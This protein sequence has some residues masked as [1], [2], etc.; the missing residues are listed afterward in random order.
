LPGLT[1]IVTTLNE[2]QNIADCLDSLAFAQEVLVIDSFS[3]DGTVDVARSHGARVI[4]HEYRSPADQKNWAIPQAANEWVLILDADERVPES[5]AAEIGE[6]VRAASRDGYQ[7]KRRNFFLGR[8]IGHSGWQN[9]WVLRLF[10]RDKGRYL[11][12]QIHERLVVD[13]EI[14][15]LRERL[16]HYSYRSMDDYWK[17]LERYA[18][19]NAAEARKRGV[20]VST[21]YMLLH[22]ALRFLKA[23]LLQ[24]GILDGKTGLVVCLLTALYAAAK[25]VHIWE[26][27][28][29]GESGRSG[30][31]DAGS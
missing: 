25:D 29:K 11:E 9:D 14:G 2:A 17:K 21:P 18:R 20:R 6:A 23:Y 24:G 27:Q 31:G 22:P 16:L 4:Q 15:R 3:T 8:E 30:S 19:W 1:A 5:L 7:I 10:R 13:G 28:N 26:M 12:R